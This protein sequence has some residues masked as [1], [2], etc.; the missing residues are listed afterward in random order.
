MIN[1]PSSPGVKLALLE[2]Q[3]LAGGIDRSAF[4]EGA[5]LLDLARPEAVSLADKFL[6]IAANQAALR[7]SLRPS[8]D[9]IVIGSGAGGSVVAGR[10][11]EDPQTQVL[12]SGR[13]RFEAERPH[14]R[15][16]VLQPGRRNGLELHCRTQC[17]REQPLHTSGNGQGFGWR[18]QH[19][20][21]GVG[22]R[23]QERFQSVGEG[24]RRPRLELCARA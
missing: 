20:W 1:I 22:P 19:Q 23:P 9:Y 24:G 11:A 6:A 17:G 3:L 2:A 5:S 4:L 12:R 14:H 8:Y 10:L 7:K 16:L 13:R 15:E 21:H 18:H